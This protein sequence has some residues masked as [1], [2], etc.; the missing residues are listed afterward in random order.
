V[1]ARDFDKVM[2]ELPIPDFMPGDAIHAELVAAARRAEDVAAGVDLPPAVNF[3]RARGLVRDA[4]ERDGI[5]SGIDSL[6]AHLLRLETGS[7][8]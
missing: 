4:L 7:L 3:I 6:V 2:L 1:G 5:A 8:P